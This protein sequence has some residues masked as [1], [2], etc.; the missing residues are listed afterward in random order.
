MAQLWR[1]KIVASQQLGDDL[2]II[3]EPNSTQQETQK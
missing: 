1:G 3:L 2:E